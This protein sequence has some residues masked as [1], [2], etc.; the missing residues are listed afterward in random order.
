LSE[1]LLIG[2]EITFDI[3]YLL[4]VWILV[5]LMWK[6]KANLLPR[7]EKIG[8][9]FMFAFFL[10]ALGDTGHV[11]FRVI[12]YGTGGLEANPLLVG[13]GSLA[14]AITVTFFYMIVAEIWRLYFN[15]NRNVIWWILMMAGVI[16]LIIMIPNANMWGS[17][18]P[19]YNWSMARNIPL[20]V[21]GIGI[22][23]V[24]LYEGIKSSDKFI[25]KISV[26]IFISYACYLPVILFIQKA[27]LLGMLMIPKTLAYVAVAVI[28]YLALFKKRVKL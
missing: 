14:T 15:R 27:P 13:M 12:A 19:P 23:I 11:G 25:K 5:I 18:V 10:L 24:L 2:M 3:L 17:V 20:I 7:V 22:A 26:M 16:R 6:N 28:A 9:L 1:S 21:Q 8:K 4:T